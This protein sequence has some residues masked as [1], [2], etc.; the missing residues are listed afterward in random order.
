VTGH[1]D[2]E[3]MLAYLAGDDAVVAAARRIW[4]A[5]GAITAAQQSLTTA[6]DTYAA[7]IRA[8][9]IPA[10]HVERLG[11]ALMLRLGRARMNADRDTGGHTGP[12][13]CSSDP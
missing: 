6:T 3:A 13:A 1:A 9:R 5:A 8:A 4:D 12:A 10:R 7:A 11:A 2:D